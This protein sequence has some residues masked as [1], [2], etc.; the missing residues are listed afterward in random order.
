[1]PKV[2]VLIAVYNAEK[3]LS[4][5]ID[6]L[7]SQSIG[8]VQIICIDDA[9]TDSSLTILRQD[10]ATHSC[11][12]VVALDT[13]H[14]QAYARNQ[15]LPLS[16]APL[17]AYLDS[18]DYMSADALEQAIRLVYGAFYKLARGYHATKVS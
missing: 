6:S 12:E 5:C 15:S 16:K 13:N 14:G 11:I 9:S 3:T 1:M 4:R 10:A 2:S 8:E 7:L 17:T 18:D